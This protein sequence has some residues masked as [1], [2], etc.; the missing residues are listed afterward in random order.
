ML[1]TMTKQ[2]LKNV[3]AAYHTQ[4]KA[5]A[6]DAN[7]DPQK[8]RKKILLEAAEWSMEELKKSSEYELWKYLSIENNNGVVEKAPPG[9]YVTH[10]QVKKLAE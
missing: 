4:Y 10:L 2:S 9:K 6:D 1:A 5:D 3:L 7:G 8:E